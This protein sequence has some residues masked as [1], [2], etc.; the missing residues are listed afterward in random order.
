MHDPELVHFAAFGLRFPFVPGREG[1]ATA[2]DCRLHFAVFGTGHPVVLLHGGM[3]NASNWANQIQALVEAGHQAVVLDTR[4]H[5][6][7]T[8][9][10]RPLSYRLFAEDVVCLMDHL[11][12]K[13]ATLVGWSDGACTALEL[14]RT[15]PERVSGVV[16]FACNVDPSGTL[17]FRMSETIRNCLTRHRL[18]F[19][20]LSPTLERFEDLQPKL[21]PMQRN[22]PNYTLEDLRNIF[23]PVVVLQGTQDEFIKLEHARTLARSL[24]SAR[25]ELLDGLGHFAPIQDPDTFNDAMLRSLEWFTGIPLPEHRPA[26]PFRQTFFHG[27]KADLRTG[28][29]L[30]VGHGSN[31]AQL[32]RLSHI[33]MAA[34]LDAAMWGAELAKGTGRER[35]YLVEPTGEIEDDPN[36]TDK[37]FPGNPTL[38]YR[39]RFP[40][41][42]V[43]EVMNWTGHPPEQVQAMKDGLARLR[44]Q[45]ADIIIDD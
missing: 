31:Y 27:T 11:G 9:G 25:L 18:D 19:E 34:T 12:L 43:G 23:V 26:Q 21:D 42:I 40:L 4:A 44:A 28:D 33:Y 29:L 36:V 7:S 22:E 17:E 14:A 15:R 32:E 10:T 41:R 39:S 13:R 30:S 37:K 38:S 6:Q 20:N 16:F 24:G 2:H 5:G 35:I 1:Y 3:G 45:G 8:S